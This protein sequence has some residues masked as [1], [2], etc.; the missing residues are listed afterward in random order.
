MKPKPFYCTCELCGS[1][2]QFGPGRY[3]GKHIAAYNLTVCQGSYVGNW[4]G[5][6][7]HYESKILDHLKA[8]GLPVP[9]RNSQDLL[10]R[11]GG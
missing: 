8:K 1:T 11:D 10:P 4:D 6:A 5:W 3:D 7:P 9:K 2:F